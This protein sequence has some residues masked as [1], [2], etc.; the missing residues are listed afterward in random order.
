[1][2]PYELSIWR[3]LQ[4]WLK[5]YQQASYGDRP[6]F[7]DWVSDPLGFTWIL[8]YLRP[9]WG[10]Y[11][12][13]AE[14]SMQDRGNHYYLFRVADKDST[15]LVILVAGQKTDLGDMASIQNQGLYY[16]HLSGSDYWTP[17]PSPARR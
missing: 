15:G 3:T 14:T 10:R 7:M 9:T 2:T 8:S 1:M 16:R 6:A 13:V 5:H 17:P 12:L 11:E 4:H